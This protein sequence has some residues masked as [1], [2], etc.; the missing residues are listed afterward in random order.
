M[1]QCFILEI[2]NQGLG[3]RL[4]WGIMSTKTGVKMDG[5]YLQV[6]R[7]KKNRVFSVHVD[8]HLKL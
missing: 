2:V 1:L 3:E 7:R 5:Y 8:K 4:T 6:E